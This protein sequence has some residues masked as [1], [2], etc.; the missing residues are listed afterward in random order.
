MLG[1]QDSYMIPTPVVGIHDPYL[2]HTHSMSSG[3]EGVQICW[4]I[5]HELSGTPTKNPSRLQYIVIITQIRPYF[6]VFSGVFLYGLDHI[7]I[8]P[9]KTSHAQFSLL[10]DQNEAIL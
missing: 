9:E 5:R 7:H 2:S 4:Q 6:W 10:E 8:P 1:V 3:H